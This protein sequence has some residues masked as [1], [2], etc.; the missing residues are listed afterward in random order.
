MPNKK[1][2][3]EAAMK[4][5]AHAPGMMKKRGMM[6]PDQMRTQPMPPAGMGMTKGPGLKMAKPTTRGGIQGR[7][8]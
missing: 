5:M 3:P 7:K 1:A 8:R 4:G 2:M 6:P